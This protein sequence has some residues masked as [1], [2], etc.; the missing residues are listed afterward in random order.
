MQQSTNELCVVCSGLKAHPVNRFNFI[1]ES[2]VCIKL[3][4]SH[5]RVRGRMIQYSAYHHF[6]LELSKVT[7]VNYKKVSRSNNFSTLLKLY[8]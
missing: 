8:S 1:W 2:P 4:G 6:L 5:N 3:S 7:S